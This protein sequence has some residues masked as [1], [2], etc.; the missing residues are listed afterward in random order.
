MDWGQFKQSELADNI[1]E[2]S[3]PV[4][5]VLLQ[6]SKKSWKCG[7]KKAKKDKKAFLKRLNK[8]EV[9]LKKT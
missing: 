4:I 3:L 5:K 2:L 9:H 6:V 8:L 7:A 1:S